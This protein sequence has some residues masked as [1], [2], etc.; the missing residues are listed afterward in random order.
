M[1]IATLIAKDE[2]ARGDISAA[3]DALRLGGVAPID[4][5]WVEAAK[6][7]DLAFSGDPKSARSALEPLGHDVVVQRVENRR[8]AMLVAD[9]DSTMITVEC[10]DELAD[11]AG[12]KAEVAA[13]TERAMLGEIDFEEALDERVALLRELED[14]VIDRCR[15]ERVRLMPGACSTTV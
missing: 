12:V 15:E 4:H 6:A 3:A 13:V 11:F 9:M 5:H 14:S 1:F 10:I 2:L 7:C 8:R